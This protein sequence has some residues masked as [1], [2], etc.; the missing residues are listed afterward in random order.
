MTSSSSRCSTIA[1]YRFTVLR[2]PLSKLPVCSTCSANSVIWRRRRSMRRIS[3]FCS[4]SDIDL[5][6]LEVGV[7]P[8]QLLPAGAEPPLD[9]GQRKRQ[10]L[11]N[12]DGGPLFTVKQLQHDLQLRRQIGQYRSHGRSRFGLND[13]LQRTRA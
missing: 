1:L 11:G 8:A 6:L 5:L 2:A 7:A 9:G 13:H 10:E 4:L 12:S 3:L